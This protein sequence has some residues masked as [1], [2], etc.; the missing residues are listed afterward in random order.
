MKH[1][2]SLSI[3]I[4]SETISKIKK[5]LP[6]VKNVNPLYRIKDLYAAAK[7]AGFMYVVCYEQIGVGRQTF[8]LYIFSENDQLSVAYREGMYIQNYPSLIKEVGYVVDQ[9]KLYETK[10]PLKDYRILNITAS[11]KS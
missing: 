6:P 8:E 1:Y 9:V 10:N 7:E 2:D 3:N 5:G 11:V 4:D